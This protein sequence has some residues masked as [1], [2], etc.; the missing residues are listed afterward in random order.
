MSN[1]WASGWAAFPTSSA[2]Q[3]SE[4][5]PEAQK[6]TA[7]NSWGAFGAFASPAPTTTSESQSNGGSG[8]SWAAAA[9]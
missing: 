1:G 2:S 9:F 3:P 6:D 4:D 8:P 7:S 5:K